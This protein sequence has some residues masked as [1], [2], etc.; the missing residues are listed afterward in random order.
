[1]SE[2][3][4]LLA[5]DHELVRQGLIS[6][7]EEAHPEWKIVASVSNGAE[8]IEQAEKLRPDVA[9]L[10]L[11]MPEPNGLKVTERLTGSV[12]GIKV[13]ILTVHAAE[14]VMRQIRRA[15]ARAF[16][17]KGEAPAHLVG[18]V[19]RMLAGES[20]FASESASRPINQLEPRERV[21]VQYL[22][23]PRELEV[24]RHLAE[25]L[26]NKQIAHLLDISVRT[27]ET[28]RAE[29]M[30]RLGVDSLGEMVRIA[31]ADGLLS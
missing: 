14:P 11:S 6:V 20:F 19:E 30:V 12:P 3:R 23:T 29:I 4:I 9:I 28:H 21:P 15:G 5:D 10:D 2:V 7:L 16:L 17:A 24:L 26:S 18:A 13:I 31:I 8:A 22:L 27:V 1:M 25:G